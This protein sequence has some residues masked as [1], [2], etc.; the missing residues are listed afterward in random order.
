MTKVLTLILLFFIN[1]ILISQND[2]I[3]YI[4][5]KEVFTN[6]ILNNDRENANDFKWIYFFE[7]KRQ[8]FKLWE[9]FDNKKHG[10]ITSWTIGKNNLSIELINYAYCYKKDTLSP[11]MID[12]IT[13]LI[14]SKNI[15]KLTPEKLSEDVHYL[16][17]ASSY[18]FSIFKKG[19]LIEKKFWYIKEEKN[20]DKISKLI[21][22]IK[23][24]SNSK[25]LWT[26][27]IGN[28]PFDCTTN[29]NYII[30]CKIYTKKE[31]LKKKRLK[32]KVERNAK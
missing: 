22:E 8:T 24:V 5:V 12:S 4:T 30:S 19:N 28:V 9:D 23:A 25:K 32:R 27:F 14:D 16:H 6:Q 10:I 3:Q 31:Y 11:Q 17:G 26:S 15:E 20:W 13:S 18:R 1:S 2:K 7:T 29:D 21:D